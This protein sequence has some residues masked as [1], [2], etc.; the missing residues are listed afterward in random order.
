MTRSEALQV[1]DKML[2]KHGCMGFVCSDCSSCE[3]PKRCPVVEALETLA[4]APP[5]S[6][7]KT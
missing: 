2:E 5:S 4:A 7:E 1:F 3:E 6:G